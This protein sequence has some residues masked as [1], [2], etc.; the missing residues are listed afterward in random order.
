[1]PALVLGG[2][3]SRRMNESVEQHL[4]L[5]R[6]I[7][8]R[9]S[10]RTKRSGTVDFDDLVQAGSLGLL[11]A[12]ERFDPSYGVS[13]K[14]YAR[15]RV[16][17]AM[18]DELRRLEPR[19]RSAALSLDAA[20]PDG[21]AH[22]LADVVSDPRATEPPIGRADPLLSNDRRFTD[23]HRFVV[24]RAAAGYSQA[25]IATMLGVSP[26]RVRQLLAEACSPS[27]DAEPK[28][29]SERECEVLA[30]TADGLTAKEIGHRLII[31][32]ATVEDHRRNATAKLA[33]RNITHA[34]AVAYEKGLLPLSPET[35]LAGL[36][37]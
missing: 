17:G 35:S 23:R 19:S 11:E 6:R 34:F 33:A 30:A 3:T 31:S 12:S 29:L 21:D 13:F 28:P 15:K 14:A 7:A 20:S 9:V 18:Y 4:A 5:V 26:S 37:S 32:P 25:E 8:R 22:A 24:G 2:P 16:L 10:T 36:E 27:A 1:V